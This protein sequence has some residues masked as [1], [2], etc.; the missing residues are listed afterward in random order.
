MHCTISFD[1]HLPRVDVCLE[2]PHDVAGEEGEG[3]VGAQV[4][5]APHQRCEVAH[6][7]RRVRDRDAGVGVQ[8]EPQEIRSRALGA[9][10]EDR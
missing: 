9:N 5:V 6:E 1:G 8:D 4:A 10:D 7:M 2:Q 3:A